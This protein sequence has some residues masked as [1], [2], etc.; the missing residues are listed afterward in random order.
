M[1]HW[2]KMAWIVVGWRVLI[3]RVYMSFDYPPGQAKVGA[4]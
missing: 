1:G 3:L 4:Q 2:R